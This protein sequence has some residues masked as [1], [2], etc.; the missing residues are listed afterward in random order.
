MR[1]E[2]FCDFVL[3]LDTI[4]QLN[5]SECTLLLFAARDIFEA[6]AVQL[7]PNELP[8]QQELFLIQ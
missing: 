2:Y 4:E 8:L 1:T 6:E 3:W 7:N 5:E